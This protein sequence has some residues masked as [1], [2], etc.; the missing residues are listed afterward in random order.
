MRTVLIEMLEGSADCCTELREANCVIEAETIE[1]LCGH[2]RDTLRNLTL[3]LKTAQADC[4]RL[5]QKHTISKAHKSTQTA[6]EPSLHDHNKDPPPSETPT[7]SYLAS[8]QGHIQY[9]GNKESESARSPCWKPSTRLQVGYGYAKKLEVQ[10][11]RR[12]A[13]WTEISLEGRRNSIQP[14]ADLN[15]SEQ[16]SLVARRGSATGRRDE[17]WTTNPGKLHRC[18]GLLDKKLRALEEQQDQT[19]RHLLQP[20]D[21]LNCLTTAKGAADLRLFRQTK[22]EF[23]DSPR[24][25]PNTLRPNTE[26]AL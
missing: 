10:S 18:L 1:G 25:I 12:Q 17:H 8:G 5:R 14:P 9:D 4:C 19:H 26:H 11:A 3:R 24:T 15:K 21:R 16:L 23:R 7:E 2:L 6:F 20:S 22:F 13:G